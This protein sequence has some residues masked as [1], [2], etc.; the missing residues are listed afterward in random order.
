M[1]VDDLAVGVDNYAQA[2][3][4]A[5]FPEAEEGLKLDGL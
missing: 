4:V 3:G 5:G 1:S 2:V